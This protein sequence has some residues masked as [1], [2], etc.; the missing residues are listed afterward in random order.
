MK[1]NTMSDVTRNAVTRPLLFTQSV[2]SRSKKLRAP[3]TK[4]DA[5]GSAV[6]CGLGAALLL[7]G[8]VQVFAGKPAWALG[9]FAAGAVTIA[10]NTA[11]RLRV[12][13]AAGDSSSRR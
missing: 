1:K 4:A 9:S 11:H 13:K 2:V 12:K 7:A 3:G 10:S 6:G 5:V 8:A